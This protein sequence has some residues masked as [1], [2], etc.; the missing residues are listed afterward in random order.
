MSIALTFDYNRIYPSGADY[1]L[2]LIMS[3]FGVKMPVASGGTINTFSDR[4]PDHFTEFESYD[5]SGWDGMDALPIHKDTIA[6]SRTLNSLLPR[7]AASDIAPGAR[8][9]IGFEWRGRRQGNNYYLLVEIGPRERT[10]V[11]DVD[12][13]GKYS[14]SDFTSVTEAWSFISRKI[15]RYSVELNGR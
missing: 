9:V 7:E 10:L 11:V 6:A 15:D 14:K 13:D 4:T 5:F 3:L 2:G 1:D 12:K 8:G